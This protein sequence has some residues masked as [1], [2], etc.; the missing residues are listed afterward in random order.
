VAFDT[1]V[2]IYAIE[3]RPRYADLAY[4]ALEWLEH[5]GHSGVTSTLTMTEILTRPYADKS[6]RWVNEYYGLLSRYPNLEWIAPDL[7]IADLAAQ[8]RARF[9]IR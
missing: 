6:K 4:H 2:F 5:T 9:G 1:S 8:F 3:E 7:E